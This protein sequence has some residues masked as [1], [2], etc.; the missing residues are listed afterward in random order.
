M[1]NA[2]QHLDRR[3]GMGAEMP[4]VFGCAAVALPVRHRYFDDPPPANQDG[5]HHFR[6]K[7][8]P[9]GFEIG[10]NLFVAGLS[11]SPVRAPHVCKAWLLS[12]PQPLDEL[13]D[14]NVAPAKQA[15]HIGTLFDKLSGGARSD[16]HVTIL[17]VLQEFGDIFGLKTTVG[18]GQHDDVTK[19]IVKPATQRTAVP[20]A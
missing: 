14:D 20:L 15:L 12:P 11:D 4:R 19:G 17:Q 5:D 16:N 6:R 8:R 13:A 9:R 7:I 2:A 3:S 10:S 18:F 1:K